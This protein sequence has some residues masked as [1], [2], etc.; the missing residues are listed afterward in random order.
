M[1]TISKRYYER[2]LPHWHP[3][4][5]N[6]FLTSRLWGSLPLSAIERIKARRLLLEREAARNS[7]TARE[8]GIRHSKKVFAFM[9]DI[10]D[11]AEHGPVWLKEPSIADLVEDALLRRYQHLYRLWAYVVMAN[12]IHVLLQPK[13]ASGDGYVLMEEITKRLKG[14]TARAANQFLNRTGQ[15]FWQD[16]SYDH[17]VRDEMEFYRVIAYIENNPVKAGL[18]TRPEDWQW[19]SARERVRRAWTEVR[20]LT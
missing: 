3:E 4:G 11:K 5:S 10:L 6:I 19:T 9:D 13:K 2:R 8:R 18:A 12:H 15:S 17:W 16:E 20:A 14:S 7:E 1:E